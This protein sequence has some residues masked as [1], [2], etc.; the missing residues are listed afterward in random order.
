[1]RI[2]REHRNGDDPTCPVRVPEVVHAG[3]CAMSS[4]GRERRH[5]VAQPGYQQLRHGHA[6]PHEIYDGYCREF[7]HKAKIGGR[8]E[9]VWGTACRSPD[10]AWQVIN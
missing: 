4:R 8:T 7:Q 6:G 9:Q 3:E 2:E 1:L 5:L 10:R